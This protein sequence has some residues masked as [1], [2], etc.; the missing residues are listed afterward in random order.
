MTKS[1]AHA[2]T[3]FS[4]L[5]GML[6]GQSVALAG[7]TQA[8]KLHGDESACSSKVAV[9]DE[10]I[11]NLNQQIEI[12]STRLAALESASRPSSGKE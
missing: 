7:P 4:L 12:L 1:R 10:L 9:R 11:R 5:L 2:V 8:P 3:S 6:F